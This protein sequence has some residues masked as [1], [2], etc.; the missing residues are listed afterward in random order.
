LQL[1]PEWSSA[2]HQVAEVNVTDPEESG[3][4]LDEERLDEAAAHGRLV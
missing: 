4:V 1:G 3:L 2:E